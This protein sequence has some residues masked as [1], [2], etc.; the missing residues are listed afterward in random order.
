MH[1]HIY[2]MTQFFFHTPTIVSSFIFSNKNNI[3]VDQRCIHSDD[4]AGFCD[5]HNNLLSFF[6]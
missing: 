3:S 4:M 5:G 1:V 2:D 6:I